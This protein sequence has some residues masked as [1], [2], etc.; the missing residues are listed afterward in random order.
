MIF[1]SKRA[2]NLRPSVLHYLAT[3]PRL[4]PMSELP[5]SSGFQKSDVNFQFDRSQL[6]PSRQKFSIS[7]S[8][9]VL[10]DRI[11][12][13]RSVCQ[14]F[15][16]RDS[17]VGNVRFFFRLLP[18]LKFFVVPAPLTST[19]WAWSTISFAPSTLSEQCTVNKSRQRQISLKNQKRRESN[20]GPLGEKPE[21]YPLCYAILNFFVVF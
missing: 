10:K 2:L 20:P 3:G 7:V 18:I 19:R 13:N 4:E 12:S 17:V 6:F 5:K 16:F 21:H 8:I 15:E 9:S 1:R 11:R 14:L